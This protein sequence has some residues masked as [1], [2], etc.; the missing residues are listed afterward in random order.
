MKVLLLLVYVLLFNT[1]VQ[2]QKHGVDTLAGYI[3]K[4]NDTIAGHVILPYRMVREKKE[5]HK[6]Y[7][8]EEWYQ[9]VRFVDGSGVEKLF[10]PSDISA[11]GWKWN[12]TLK[13]TFRSFKV[14]VPHKGAFQ[15]K[16]QAKPFLKVEI[17]GPMSLYLY[18]HQENALGSTN[19]FNDR[20]LINE[21]GEMQPIK[22]KAWLGIA[23][24]LT[25]LESWFEGYPDLSKFNMKDMIALEVWYLVAGYNKWRITANR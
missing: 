10:L 22:I 6:Q 7:E 9:Q 12:D 20:Y 23:Y 5:F 16:G 21:Q 24:N 25:D 1:Y 18:Y 14:E 11:Y 3:V 8:N 2:A 19:Y 4:T 13:A 17:E 15:F